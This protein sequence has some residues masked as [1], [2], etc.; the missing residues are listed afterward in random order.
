[1]TRGSF[2]VTRGSL[3]VTRG[4]LYVTRGLVYVTRGA[5][6]IT[7]RSVETP[8]HQ[9]DNHTMASRV[10]LFLTFFASTFAFPRLRLLALTF[11]STRLRHFAFAFAFPGPQR[12]AM[13]V[14]GAA[15]RV[16]TETRKSVGGGQG[17]STNR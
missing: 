8:L 1:V 15:A 14:R 13:D 4:S 12:L 16:Q 7:R 9:N 2:Y 6:K 11:A 10:L 3:Y 5:I 17:S